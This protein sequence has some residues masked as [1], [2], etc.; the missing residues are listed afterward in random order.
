MTAAGKA[1][2]LLPLSKVDS[3]SQIYMEGRYK[4]LVEMIVNIV[5]RK[6]R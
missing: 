4:Q 5:C 2:I 6:W 3:L 1:V